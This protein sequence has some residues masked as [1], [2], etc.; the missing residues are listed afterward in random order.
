[1]EKIR[2]APD[3]ASFTGGIGVNPYIAGYPWNNSTGFGTRFFAPSPTPGTSANLSAKSSFPKAGNAICIPTA[4]SPYIC[5]HFYSSSGFG[6][7][8]PVQPSV[9]STNLGL[10]SAFGRIENVF[11]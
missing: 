6:V 10:G 5:T 3:F 7:R 11:T 1:M 8:W 2:M 9:T 4:G